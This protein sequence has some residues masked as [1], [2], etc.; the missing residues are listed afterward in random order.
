MSFKCINS[1]V[2]KLPNYSAVRIVELK[3][4]EKI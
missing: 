1:I 2:I 3:I 4:K